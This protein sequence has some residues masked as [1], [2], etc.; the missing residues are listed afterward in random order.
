MAAIRGTSVGS[1]PRAISTATS[2]AVVAMTT[3]MTHSEG[4][5]DQVRNPYTSVTQIQ[6]T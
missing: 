3:P 4:P 2:A 6:I 5:G 1:A